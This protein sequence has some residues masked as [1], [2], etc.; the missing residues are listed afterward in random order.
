[1][2]AGYSLSNLSESIFGRE[3]VFRRSLFPHPTCLRSFNYIKSLISNISKVSSFTSLPLMVDFCEFSRV[4]SRSLRLRAEVVRCLDEMRL[5]ISVMDGN[6][7]VGKLTVFVW[8]EGK[9]TLGSIK[10]SSWE[11]Q[12]VQ[13]DRRVHAPFNPL[14]SGRSEAGYCSPSHLFTISS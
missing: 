10:L 4:C 7:S 1:M 8:S 13:P 11:L 3:G 9:G 14:S 2:R 12:Q 5:A 6:L